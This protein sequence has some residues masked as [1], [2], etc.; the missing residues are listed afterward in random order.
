MG[1]RPCRVEHPRPGGGAARRIGADL[2]PPRGH[3][4]ALRGA[5]RCGQ[6]GVFGVSEHSAGGK[7]TTKKVG[8]NIFGTTKNG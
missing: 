1:E 8:I 3:P 2:L 7:V 4:A 6:P 5:Q